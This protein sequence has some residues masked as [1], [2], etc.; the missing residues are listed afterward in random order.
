MS[1]AALIGV[2]HQ[3]DRYNQA[4]A[5]FMRAD[6]D[7]AGELP[8]LLS[9]GRRPIRGRVDPIHCRRGFCRLDFDDNRR[10]DGSLERAGR[11]IGQRR[12]GMDAALSACGL[13]CD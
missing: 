11:G 3:L 13:T 6:G 12:L 8:I 2:E 5:P 10:G 4:L 7:R 9:A 1:G